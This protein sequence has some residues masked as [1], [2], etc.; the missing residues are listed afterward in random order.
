[1]KWKIILTVYL[2]FLAGSTFRTFRNIL[3]LNRYRRKRPK[4][5]ASIFD[6]ALSHTRLSD[7]SEKKK[8]IACPLLDI[9][10]CGQVLSPRL[11]RLTIFGPPNF[12]HALQ[13]NKAKL[14]VSQAWNFYSSISTPV[15]PNSNIRKFDLHH[16]KAKFGRFNLALLQCSSL[17]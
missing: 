5:D 11:Y 8:K 6:L 15:R 2:V 14:T 3:G 1:M 16:N 13:R 9:F 10:A 17:T 7:A 4:V 12:F